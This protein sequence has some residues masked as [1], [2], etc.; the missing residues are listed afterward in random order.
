MAAA[1]TVFVG[2]GTAGTYLTG[3][4]LGESFAGGQIFFLP[5]LLAGIVGM[6]IV[7]KEKNAGSGGEH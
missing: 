5:L 6:K 2:I 3:I 1:Y 4:F 7:T